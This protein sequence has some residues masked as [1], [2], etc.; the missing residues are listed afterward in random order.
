MDAMRVAYL[1]PNGEI[2]LSATDRPSPG[3]GEVLVAVERVGICGSDLHYYERGGNGGNAVEGRAVLGHECAGRVAATGDAVTGLDVGDRVAVEP[4]VPC[5]DCARCRDGEYNLCADV[6]FMGS[7]PDDGAFRE[8]VAWPA[9]F[10]YRLPEG[11]STAEGALCEPL[12]VGLHLARRS[13]VGAGDT[14]LVTGA[15]TV[16]LLAADA[17]RMAGADA[18][19]VTDAVASKL[20]LAASRGADACIDAT[21]ADVGE[22]FR[23]RVDADG[24]DVVVE[25]SG[26]PAA[27]ESTVDAVRRGGV[28]TFVGMP[29]GAA[30]PAD[31]LGLV[32]DEL[33]LR[34]SYRYHHTYPDAVAAVAS[35]EVDLRGLVSFAEPLDRLA[36]AFERAADPETVKGMVRVG[37]ST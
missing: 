36:R 29:D 37:G 10:V 25:A 11:V 1:T 27:V 24:A 13:G 8:F 35:G 16:G 33:D 14:V 4:G 7:P 32:N 2:E 18:V 15:G 26:S 19:A 21:E 30:L 17:I 20:D 12:S 34:G 3:T 31:V 28:V 5:G 23:E 22:A 9:D 6:T